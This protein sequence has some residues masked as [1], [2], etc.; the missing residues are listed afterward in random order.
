MFYLE[1]YSNLY[2]HMLVGAGYLDISKVLTPEEK[3]QFAIYKD[4]KNVNLAKYLKDITISIDD[5]I[6]SSE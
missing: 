3:S 2:M 6:K 4:A 5:F 1:G